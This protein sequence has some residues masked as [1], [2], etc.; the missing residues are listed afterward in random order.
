MAAGL[1]LLGVLAV[2]GAAAGCGG[3]S[4]AACA[5][6]ACVT[7]AL[8]GEGAL[9]GPLDD[10]TVIVQA[11]ATAWRPPLRE[12]LVRLPSELLLQ[13]PAGLA[14]EP[15]LRM[16][17]RAGRDGTRL[18]A[19]GELLRDGRPGRLPLTLERVEADGPSARSSATLAHDPVSGRLILTGGRRGGA[20]LAE[21]WSW[22]GARWHKATEAGLPA[23][24]GH[25]VALDPRRGRLLLFGGRG[26]DGA[27]LGDTWLFDGAAWQ[28]SEAAGPPA[29]AHAALA[30]V[31][32]GLLLSGGTGA[33]DASLGDT[34]L[35][36]GQGWR[37]VT[38][39]RD[40]CPDERPATASGPR[41]R[42]GASLVPVGEAAFL[43]GGLLG[44]RPTSPPELDEAAWRW[45]GAG[46]SALPVS[47]AAALQRWLGVAAPL[48]G[49]RVLL[50]G[51]QS[52][53]GPRQDFYILDTSSGRAGPLLGLAPPARSEAALAYDPLRDEAILFGGEGREQQATV[54]LA[55]T[56]SFYPAAGWERLR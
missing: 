42:T 18:A 32:D 38:S 8:D 45:G 20:V 24:S 47:P 48:P 14:T 37:E 52:S 40:A 9:A 50:G 51:G 35:W 53:G 6:A 4:E 31:A 23:R 29:R 55:D 46:F 19:A 10:V 7:L 39:A 1:G 2:L 28:R 11:G 34:W 44:P 16:T 41:C 33:T 17:V 36:D 26:S 13:L 3:A 22:D 27:L 5:D 54:E 12:R 21:Q 30:P 49:G 56:W 25:A 43:L 15:R